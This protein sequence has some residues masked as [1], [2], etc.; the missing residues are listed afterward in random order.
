M[1]EVIDLK[2]I[3]ITGDSEVGKSTLALRLNEKLKCPFLDIDKVILNSE[4]LYEPTFGEV[5]LLNVDIEED[6]SKNNLPS[7]P[8]YS[9]ILEIVELEENTIKILNRDITYNI[10][11]NQEIDINSNVSIADGINYSY[12]IKIIKK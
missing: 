4:T 9:T 11:Y 2:L 12:S 3:G 7:I 5:W 6:N 10:K 8:R 1:T